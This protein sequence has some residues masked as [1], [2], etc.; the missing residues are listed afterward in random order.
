[1]GP[2]QSHF[3]KRLNL[4]SQC[5]FD[6]SRYLTNKYFGMAMG[7]HPPKTPKINFLNGL[8][9]V[10]SVFDISRYLTDKDFDTVWGYN[11]PRGSP[12]WTS[13]K[14]TFLKSLA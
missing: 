13:Q 8:T 7:Y 2:S 10:A 14:I 3:F 6:I 4:G 5:F 9:S 11:P 12:E 1:M